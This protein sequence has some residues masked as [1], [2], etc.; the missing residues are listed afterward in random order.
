MRDMMEAIV[1][2]FKQEDKWKA[3]ICEEL[4]TKFKEVDDVLVAMHQHVMQ[5]SQ[6][7]AKRIRFQNGQLLNADNL[8]DAFTEILNRFDKLEKRLQTLETDYYL[9]NEERDK[10]E[11]AQ[12]DGEAG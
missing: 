5:M 2:R 11:Q 7:D 3:K 1:N 9:L 4:R 6:M 12:E 10:D 8:N